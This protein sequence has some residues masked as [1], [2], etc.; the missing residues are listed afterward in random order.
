[1]NDTAKSL[2]NKQIG[3]LHV[4]KNQNRMSDDEY[5]DLLKHA[6]NVRTACE[7]DS[8]GMDKVLQLM[9]DLGY[10]VVRFEPAP[11]YGD[12]PGMATAKQIA[13]LDGLR[14]QIFG[15]N[16]TAK[17][18]HWLENHFNVTHVRFMDKQTASKVINGLKAMQK[19]HRNYYK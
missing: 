19:S 10:E 12:R 4:L 7:L 11:D 8:E 2:T 18:Q 15:K 13:Y 5:R 16:N 14:Q 1:M 6:A 9:E 17:F 3:Y